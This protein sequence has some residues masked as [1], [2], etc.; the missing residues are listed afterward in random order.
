MPP[1]KELVTKI[2]DLDHFNIF[3][4]KENPKLSVIDVYVNWAGPC[5][6]LMNPTYKR[7]TNETDDW[8]KRLEFIEV[9]YEKIESLQLTAKVSCRPKF[10]L[11]LNGSKVDEVNGTNIP[12]LLSKIEKYIPYP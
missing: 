6:D 9:D 4:N 2:K 8:E 5:T 11:L 10:I 12:E 1:K 7:L 3:Y